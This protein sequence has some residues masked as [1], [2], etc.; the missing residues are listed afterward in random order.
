MGE[1]SLWKLPHPWK[2]VEHPLSEAIIE[3]A[4]EKEFHLKMLRNSTPFQGG[5][6]WENRR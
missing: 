2:A 6:L 1:D 4:N 5:A 3:K